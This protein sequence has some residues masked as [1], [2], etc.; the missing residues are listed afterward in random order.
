MRPPR[1]EPVS[2]AEALGAGVRCDGRTTGLGC[3]IQFSVP[4]EA[5]GDP[6]CYKALA[7]GVLGA[8]CA[9]CYPLLRVEGQAIHVTEEDWGC[10]VARSVSL[11]EGGLDVIQVHG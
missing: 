7:L 1:R 5:R 6:G 8:V 2:E 4:L 10:R 9:V 3:S 11:I